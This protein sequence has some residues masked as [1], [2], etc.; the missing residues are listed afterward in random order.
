VVA[1]LCQGIFGCRQAVRIRGGSDGRIVESESRL[2]L[3]VAHRPLHEKSM[4]M[5]A[6]GDG[7]AIGGL[8]ARS[9]GNSKLCRERF[10]PES[11][12]IH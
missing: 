2:Q 12:S 6:V 9:V 11:C 10:L 8:S 4:V 1:R 7:V 5:L 3:T